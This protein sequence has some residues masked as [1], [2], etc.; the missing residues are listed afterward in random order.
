MIM[1]TVFISYCHKDE[2][3]KDR[4][5]T[6]LGVL[7]QESSL[8]VWDDRRIGAGEDWYQKIQEAIARAS[9][10]VL[11][12]SAD[13]LTSKFIL[14][15]EIPSLL[16]RMDNEGLRIF[17]VIIRPC[18]WKRV[19]WLARMNIRPKDGKPIS[20]GAK[21]QIDANLAA[22]ADEVA[23]IIES[24]NPIPPLETSS[25]APQKIPPEYKDWVRNFHSTISYDQLAKKGEALPVQ[26][27]EVYIHLETVNP[28]HKAEMERTSKDRGENLKEP[29]TIDI[30]ALLERVNCILLRGKAGMGKTTLIKHLANT[31]TEGSCQSTLR[32][33]L[34]VIV[35]LKDLWLVYREEIK[36]F[37]KRITF[38]P[39]LDAYLE[40]IKCPLNWSVISNFVHYNK[41]LFITEVTAF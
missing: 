34:P 25:I 6:Q 26:L 30:E 27:L 40:K 38:E 23:A 16:E 3:W 33:Y 14:S 18:V 41:A 10:A 17:P 29:A 9:V 35:F 12:V 22:I 39:L 20:N 37:K 28:F 8:D 31:I 24:K 21:H 2:V 11:L 13:F 15:K 4:L 1:S 32:D 7:Q 19:K 36:K 5:V